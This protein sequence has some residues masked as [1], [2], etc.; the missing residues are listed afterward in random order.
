MTKVNLSELYK[1]PTT[2]NGYGVLLKK[3]FPGRTLADLFPELLKMEPGSWS[4]LGY[5]TVA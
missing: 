5:L 1:L 4:K 2:A 3:F